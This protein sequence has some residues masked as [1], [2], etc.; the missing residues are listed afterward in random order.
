MHLPTDSIPRE[1]KVDALETRGTQWGDISVRYLEL[2]PGVDFT[3][4]LKGLPQDQCLSPHWGYVLHG[5][6]H[7]RY[8]NGDE[9]LTQAG[10]VFYWPA[11]HTGWTQEGITFL[12]FSP[13]SEIKPVLDHVQAQMAG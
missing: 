11:G 7:L 13:A 8:A 3:P 9:E 1:L 4:L 12:E 6:I 5:S 10:E 2:P